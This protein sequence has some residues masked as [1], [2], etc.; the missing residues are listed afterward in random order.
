MRWAGELSGPNG[1]NTDS[2]GGDYGEESSPFLP[3]FD[4]RQSSG[5]DLIGAVLRD[6]KE[7]HSRVCRQPAMEG[8]LAEVLVE[9]KQGALTRRAKGDHRLIGGAGQDF[10]DPGYV[11]PRTSQG[12]HAG[13][14][15]V[16]VSQQFQ[17]VLSGNSRSSRTRSR[18]YARQDRMSSGCNVG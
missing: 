4:D 8:E 17:A 12:S 3:H 5:R 2:S 7:D 11:E 6:T 16:L 13:A 10:G 1:S 9:R 18:A 14:G 15:K